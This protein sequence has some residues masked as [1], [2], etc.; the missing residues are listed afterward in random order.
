[1][2]RA[3]PGGCTVSGLFVRPPAWAAQKGHSL[4]P[5]FAP[6]ASSRLT[7]MPFQPAQE[8]GRDAVLL[9][10]WLAGG[11][12]EEVDRGRGF[13]T[14]LFPISLSPAPH[15]VPSPFFARATFSSP[16]VFV[17]SNTH[18]PHPQARP[19]AVQP[20]RT[21]DRQSIKNKKSSNAQRNACAPGRR[22]GR[23]GWRWCCDCHCHH[24][25]CRCRPLHPP[26]ARLHV[27]PARVGHD[28]RGSLVSR[29]RVRRAA[30][31]AGRVQAPQAVRRQQSPGTV[32]GRRA[33][34]LRGRAQ[35]VWPVLA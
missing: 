6:R 2:A 29:R 34:P 8:A 26:A 25:F 4:P 15:L 31:P 33:R 35:D 18:R 30:Q 14:P 13:P 12:R 27:R 11:A 22:R 3:G 17:P 21:S 28:V 1:V 16:L 10:G 32:D 20:H 9:V 23:V 7:P 24:R 19:A 5:F